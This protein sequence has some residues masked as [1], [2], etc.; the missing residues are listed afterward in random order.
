MTDQSP[1]GVRCDLRVAL[2]SLAAAFE[3]NVVPHQGDRSLEP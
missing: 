1:D 3:I 2:A